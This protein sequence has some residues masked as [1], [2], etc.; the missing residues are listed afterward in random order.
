MAAPDAPLAAVAIA[1]RRACSYAV[2]VAVNRRL[3]FYAW[4]DTSETDPFDRVKA[5]AGVAGLDAD[6]VVLDQGEDTLTAVEIVSAGDGTETTQLLLH[7]LHGP[8]SRPSEW[9]PGEGIHP[10]QIGEGSYTAF[11]SHVTIWDDKV[12]AI[13]MHA[14]SPGLGRLSTYFWRQVTARVAFRPLFNQDMAERLK[15][16]EGVRGVEFSIH[17]PHKIAEARKLGMLGSVLPRRNFPSI[18]VSAGMSRKDPHDA[19]VDDELAKELFEIAD[20]AEQ[21]F[22]RIR[23]RGRSKTEKT[24]AGRQKTI[25]INLLSERLQIERELDSD[26][27]NPS[28][29]DQANVFAALDIARTTLAGDGRLQAAVEARLAYDAARG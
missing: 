3:T 10:I 17:E 4:T 7:A 2:S 8:G 13:D 11:T 22:D 1:A 9:G 26:S 19:Y 12:A 5:A 25:E 29:P 27:E 23:I 16:L 6:D 14:N 20:E 18:H 15:D 28:L 24:A 21:F